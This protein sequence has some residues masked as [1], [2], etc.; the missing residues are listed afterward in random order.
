M[1]GTAAGAARLTLAVPKETAP[2]ERR[3]ALI[4]DAVKKYAS[5]GHTVLIESGAGAAAFIA[6]EF[7]T[8]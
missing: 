5:S 2:N 7:T 1:E 3:V 4:P 8:V 6:D